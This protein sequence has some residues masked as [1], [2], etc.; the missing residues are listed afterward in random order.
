MVGN[1]KRLYLALYP[2]GMACGH[3]ELKYHLAFLMSPKVEDNPRALA[4]RFHVKNPMGTGWRYVEDVITDPRSSTRLLVRILIA[5]ITDEGGLIEVFRNT[6][7]C[8]DD[9]KFDC[10]SWAVDALSRLS[11]NGTIVG[12]SELD[13]DKIREKAFS[14]A[15][16]KNSGGRFS[17]GQDMT[18]PKPTWDMLQDKEII[19]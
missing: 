1:K 7:I 8:R 9:P 6:P 3:T 14:Y 19:P 4:V 13:W 16:G 17:R 2:V 18:K 5:K 12:T 10:Q 11:N 15:A